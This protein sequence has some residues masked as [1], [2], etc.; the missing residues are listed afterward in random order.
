M[1][2]IATAVVLLIALLFTSLFQT[3]KTADIRIASMD[4]TENEIFA[5]MLS[6]SIERAGAGRGDYSGSG[7]RFRLHVFDSEQ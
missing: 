4:F 3:K 2:V 5:Y 1:F 6:E 7:S